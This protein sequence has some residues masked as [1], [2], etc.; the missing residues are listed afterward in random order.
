MIAKKTIKEV[1]LKVDEL[2]GKK[3]KVGMDE[4][5]ILAKGENDDD[6][7]TDGYHKVVKIIDG[8]E[9]PET[10]VVQ[11]DTELLKQKFESLIHYTSKGKIIKTEALAEDDIVETFLELVRQAG[12]K[13]YNSS[14][15][16]DIDDALSVNVSVAK[17]GTKY[18]NLQFMIYPD[19]SVYFYNFSHYT[20]LTNL[21]N[22]EKLI[23]MIGDIDKVKKMP[24]K[25]AVESSI[26]KY[27]QSLTEA[28]WLTLRDTETG[29]KKGFDL[30]TERFANADDFIT[31]MAELFSGKLIADKYGA[32]VELK[33]TEEKKEFAKALD[34]S[35]IFSTFVGYTFNDSQKQ[36]LDIILHF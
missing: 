6:K 4:Y 2:A 31:W 21:D 32:S 20:Y 27:T 30:E 1:E 12:Y 8:K 16:T 19:T 17:P 9:D 3:Y 24:W 23:G 18:K 10:A 28:P 13:V 11:S 36:L 29:K 26:T 22:K 14:I 35:M 33:T 7:V 34:S 25:V 15:D 5:H